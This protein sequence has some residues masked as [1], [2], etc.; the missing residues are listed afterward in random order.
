[1]GC[2]K[3]QSRDSPA[4]TIGEQRGFP[5]GTETQ[6]KPTLGRI[7][8]ENS[9]H[10]KGPCRGKGPIQGLLFAGEKRG[11]E[12]KEDVLKRGQVPIPSLYAAWGAWRS[13]EEKSEWEEGC[14]FNIC[15]C[16]L[17]PKSISTSSAN[18][19][20][21]KSVLLVMVVGRF[22]LCLYLDPGCLTS[23]ILLLPLWGEGWMSSGVGA[24]L[25]DNPNPAQ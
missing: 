18:F 4:D 2:P 7:N 8:L 11:R 10:W 6:R 25:L 24:W 21:V 19:P 12:Q 1:M 17:L 23:H 13:Q 3:C 9:N 16:F 5:A 14:C 20:E 22:C 15:L